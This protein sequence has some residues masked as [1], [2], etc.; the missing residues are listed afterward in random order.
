[1]T[2]AVYTDRLA[3]VHGRGAGG[4]DWGVLGTVH[5]HHAHHRGVHP[6]DGSE[7]VVPG[8][9]SHLITSSLAPLPTYLPKLPTYLL[10]LS[11]AISFHTSSVAYPPLPTLSFVL[12]H[13]LFL[14]CLISKITHF[15]NNSSLHIPAL[16]LR[17]PFLH[18]HLTHYF[19]TSFSFIIIIPPSL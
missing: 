8:G 12:L 15:F 10:H 17:Y 1:M 2:I 6:R 9:N 3:V 18:H 4:D 7:V 13:D 19:T 16:T 11:A 5:P 14:H